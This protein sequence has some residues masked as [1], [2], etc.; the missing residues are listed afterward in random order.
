MATP[1]LT[2]EQQQEAVDA[3]NEY[4]NKAEAARKL[5]LN[6]HTFNSRLSNAKRSGLMLSS[7]AQSAIRSAGLNAHEAKA[8]WIVQVDPETNSRTS[9]YWRAPELEPES[10]VDLFRDAFNGI[11][12]SETIAAPDLINQDLITLYPVMD[13][14]YGMIAWGEETGSEDYDIKIATQD[15]RHAF[16]K[17]C[18]LTPNSG[19]AILLIGGDFFHADDNRAETPKSRHKLD[20]DGRHW[21]VISTG[22]DLLADVI[23]RLLNKHHT[24]TVR[25]L[26]GNHDEHSHLILTF[27][28]SERYRDEPRAKIEKNPHD[29][30]MMQWGKCL[31]SAHHGDKAKAD[32]LTMYLSDVCPYWSDTRHRYMLT[33]HIHHDAAKD[34]GPLRW[35]SLRAFCPPDAYAAGMGYASRRALQAMTFHKQDGLVLRAIDP[36]ER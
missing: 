10:I 28:L 26:R 35:E 34:V 18:A 1:K 14:H 20:V 17:V 4:E 3:Y 27:A 9:T 22:I 32:R 8:G 31:I 25:V 12:A 30:F 36:I 6:Y 5:G 13:A 16:S 29:L 24:V 23:D 21:R 7:G 11:T 19:E 33:G 2:R 15:M